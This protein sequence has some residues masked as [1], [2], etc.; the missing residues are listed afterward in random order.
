MREQRVEEARIVQ[1]AVHALFLETALRALPELLVSRSQQPNQVYCIAA[2]K[3]GA[4]GR[5]NHFVLLLPLWRLPHIEHPLG[6][7]GSRRRP[8]HSGFGRVFPDL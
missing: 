2:P 4:N 3:R 1:K 8:L 5:K 7:G 6:R